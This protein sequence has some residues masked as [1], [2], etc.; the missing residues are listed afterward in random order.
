M[1]ET[2]WTDE[3]QQAMKLT[4]MRKTEFA[5]GQWQVLE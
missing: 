1:S 5:Q 4:Y 2:K 3:Q